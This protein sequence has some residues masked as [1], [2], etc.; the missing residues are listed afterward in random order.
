VQTGIARQCLLPID[1]QALSL[2][3]SIFR[4]SQ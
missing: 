2:A 4:V 3:R 1:G